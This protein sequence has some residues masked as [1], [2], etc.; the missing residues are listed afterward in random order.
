M[1]SRVDHIAMTADTLGN[2][3]INPDTDLDCHVFQGC[4]G[5]FQIY[6]IMFHS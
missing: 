2:L 1:L 3:K 5:F 6:I 4:V